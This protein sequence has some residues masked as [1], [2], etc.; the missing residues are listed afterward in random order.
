MKDSVCIVGGCGH[1]GLPLGIAL[2]ETGLD[3]SLL[4][5]DAARVALVAAGRMPFLERGAHRALAAVLASGR[6]RVTTSTAQVPLTEV[7]IVTIGTPVDEFMDPS[8]RAFDR[9]IEQV[10]ARMRDGQL[11]ILRSTLFPGVTDRLSR[12]VAERGLDIDI[13]HCPERIAQGYALEELTDLPQIVGGASA[14]ALE[15]S[16]ALFERLGV[17]VISLPPVEAELSKL[18]SN[19]YRYISFAIANQ[20]Y[21]IAA[22]FGADF[23]RI[24]RAMV[25]DYPRMSGFPKAGFAGGPCLLKDT[26]QLAAFNHNAFVI[27]QAAMMVNEGLPCVLVE[28]AKAHLDLAGATAAILGMAFKGNS[29]DARDSLAYKL[30]KILTVECRRVLC[31]DPYIED[32]TFVSLE[33]AL[34]EADVVFVGACHEAYQDLVVDKPLFDVFHFLRP[35]QP[36]TVGHRSAA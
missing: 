14:R 36:E 32:P 10:L 34:D 4:D 23:D 21:T 27:G 24:R 30:R 8:V 1:V 19:A 12:K 35:P 11:L 22:R 17:T 5:I 31:T 33:T 20:F 6:L 16:R 7:V 29:D 15:R 9:A 3:V 25:T 26:M 18:F 28:A 2:A 13:A